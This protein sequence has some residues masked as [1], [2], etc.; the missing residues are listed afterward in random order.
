MNLVKKLLNSSYFLVL[1]FFLLILAFSALFY[2]TVQQDIESGQPSDSYIRT[3]AEIANNP[4]GT[5]TIDSVEYYRAP[6][7]VNVEISEDEILMSVPLSGEMVRVS[8]VPDMKIGTKITVKYPDDNHQLIMLTDDPKPQHRVFLY[9]LYSLIILGSITGFILFLRRNRIRDHRIVME[10]NMRK[11][12]EEK[13]KSES[14]SFNSLDRT[15]SADDIFNPFTDSGIDYNAKYE[16]D[17]TMSDAT[18]NENDA[19]ATFGNDSFYAENGSVYEQNG[20]AAPSYAD[21]GA[22]VQNNQSVPTYTSFGADVQNNQPV[23][24]YASFG[25]D[26][27]NNQSVPSYAS[28]GA[29]ASISSEPPRTSENSGNGN[30]PQEN[31]HSYSG[32]GTPDPSMDTP[33][34][35]TAP[36]T[37]YGA[38][39]P[40]MDSEYDPFAPYTGY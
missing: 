12:R 3:T 32:H 40:S 17:K 29:A 35:P 34:D 26:V 4:E 19:F 2:V 20:N 7:Y 13:E 6:I 27:Q 14:G 1:A 36:Y 23:P 18:F 9:V 5:I 24:P 31:E 28:F 10:E 8:Q 25:A 33:Y 22:G 38:P 15:V 21:L 16:H 30:N 37:G 39:N 11:M